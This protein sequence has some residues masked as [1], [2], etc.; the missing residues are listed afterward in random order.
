VGFLRVLLFGLLLGVCR[1]C[2]IFLKQF[3]NKKYIFGGIIMSKLVQNLK[4]NEVKTIIRDVKF[5]VATLSCSILIGL[6]TCVHAAD[7]P[8]IAD[9][10]SSMTSTFATVSSLCL[11]A[12]AAIAPVGVTIFGAMFV[13]KKGI[14]FFKDLTKA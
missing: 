5:K 4:S 9:V 11:S 1:N 10:T 3:H 2:S 6:Q 12:L 7:T 8:N 13:W 14:G